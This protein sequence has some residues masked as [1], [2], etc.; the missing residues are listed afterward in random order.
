MVDGV[1]IAPGQP[2]AH[3]LQAEVQLA[4]R[5]KIQMHAGDRGAHRQVRGIH[6]LGAQADTREREICNVELE[7]GA[8]AHL[9]V[10]DIALGDQRA[11]AEM[12][13]ALEVVELLRERRGKRRATLELGDL[14]RADHEVH[15]DPAQR[16]REG[17]LVGRQQRLPLGLGGTPVEDKGAAGRIHMQHGRDHLVGATRT[18]VQD[19]LLPGEVAQHGADLGGMGKAIAVVWQR[20][21]VKLGLLRGILETHENH[22]NV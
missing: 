21:G 15:G 19:A 2:V 20:A 4:Q 1:V 7:H 6:G 14:G 18:H 8:V 5:A 22:A 10:A 12:T 17:I 16:R 3:H 13:A 11:C 9:D